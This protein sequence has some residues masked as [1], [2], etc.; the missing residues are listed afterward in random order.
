MDFAGG[1]PIGIVSK[2]H[3]FKGQVRLGFYKE[4]FSKA[5]KNKGF[6]FLEIEKKGV[7]FF[8]ISVEQGGK[9]VQL[10]DVDSDEQAKKL[11][12]LKILSFDENLA[13]EEERID[14]YIL[15]NQDGVEVGQVVEVID[16]KGNVVLLV[17]VG[18]DKK[19]IPFH[20]DLIEEIDHNIKIIRLIIPEGL[21]DI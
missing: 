16:L 2:S 4:E 8:I 1:F 11:I 13:S 5:I 15:Q 3:G 10:E 6:L 20:E 12:G 7:P 14:G 18:G 19:M 9:I 17:E 21:L